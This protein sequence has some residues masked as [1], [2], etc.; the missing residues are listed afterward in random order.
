MRVAATRFT[1][2]MNYNNKIV[3]LIPVLFIA[4]ITGIAVVD[5]NWL[6]FGVALL[7]FVIYLCFKK[8]I[9]FPFGLYVFLL[10]FDNLLSVVG[11]GGGATLTKLLGILT[12]LV[13]SLKGGIENKLKKPDAILLWWVLFVIY[14]FFTQWWALKPEFVQGRFTT[15][16]GL[17]LLYLVVACYKFEKKDFETVK[18]CILLGGVIAAF[19][20]VYFSTT[21]QFIKGSGGRTSLLLGDTKV[22]PNNL[23]LSLLLPVSICIEMMLDKSKK[24]KTKS[25][26]LIMF[27]ILLFAV[28]A[29]GSRGGLVS[30]GVVIISYIL[31]LKQRLTLGIIL[32]I[33]GICILSIIPPQLFIGRWE[34]AIASGGSGRLDIWHVGCVALKKYWVLGAGLNNFTE[35]FIEFH[36]YVG[37][38]LRLG[39]APVAHNTYLQIAVELGIV[40]FSLTIW[41]IIKHYRAISS[42]F[43]QYNSDIVMLKASFWSILACCFFITTIMNKSFWLLWMMIMMHKNI[44][45]DKSK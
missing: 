14:A 11:S 12:I 21:G 45:V 40:G 26:Y 43:I 34:G 31:F 6:Y 1:K 24:I 13:L 29:T 3:W 20:T 35:V 36:K 4:I 5:N 8:P 19:I 42:R 28:F 2:R 25:L 10:P 38:P 16:V 30:V 37:V 41:G 39:G 22:D 33:A 27:G 7:P 15:I 44:Y 9:L 23:V 17:L 32:I 18:W